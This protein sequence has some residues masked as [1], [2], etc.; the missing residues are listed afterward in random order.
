[1]LEEQLQ[2]HFKIP[3]QL[4]D[5]KKVTP[6]NLIEDLEFEKLHSDISNNT[7]YEFL[8]KPKTLFGRSGISQWIKNYTT[9]IQF[10]KDNQNLITQF[11]NCPNET[12]RISTTKA[13]LSFKNIKEDDNFIDKYQYIN[14]DKLEFLNKSSIF[15][16]I[17]SM[18]S[19][20][21]PALNII[22]PLLLLLI[23][24]ILLRFKKIPI[25]LSS[26]I[27]IL[28]V[29]LRNHSFGKLITQWGV[30]P[31]GQRIYMLLMVGMYIY[32]IYQN[33]ISCYQF[34]KNS[35]TINSDITNIRDHLKSMK[36]K[37]G[38][39]MSKIHKYKSFTPY[40]DYLQEKLEKIN[41]L[42]HNLDS[43]PLASFNPNKIPL[44]GYTMKQYYLLYKSEDIKDTLLFSFGFYGYLEKLESI[45]QLVKSK[46][47][48]KAQFYKSKK[49]RL[50]LSKAYY[51]TMIADKVIPNTIS[52]TR[53]KLI[54]GPNAS[55]KTT[56]LKTA[57]TNLLLSQQLGFG[58]YTKASITPFDYIHCYLN[59]PDTS[60]R[61]SLFQAEA[62][63]CLEILNTINN[64]KDKKHFCI[65]DELFSGTNPYEAISSAQSYLQHIS[66][67]SNV[68]FML[69]THFTKL[70]KNLN[71]NNSI[72][73]INMH[74][75][76]TDDIPSY[77]YT[78]CK[79]ISQI[80]GGIIVLKEL[81]YPDNI[82]ASTKEIINTF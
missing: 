15:L 19:I 55:G 9:D 16:S 69:T 5:N 36:N 43:V 42:H 50:R 1:M 49:P 38:N 39:F 23:P 73:N 48:N 61:D 47:L 52:M 74:T 4:I 18:Y 75:I 71:T 7:I 67:I 53:N 54:T 40:F 41:N 2:E 78:I 64:N 76:I 14:W 27:S 80:K 62:R 58:F 17:L 31:W 35:Y 11:S 8:L 37:L 22:A 60:S 24:F 66:G 6:P 12:D 82:V 3:I 33:A 68:R 26:Y 21:S 20:V 51:P 10:L 13:W 57:T 63:R 25:T 28:M 72:D 77:N 30:L 81:G 79:G 46:V 29:S 59:I 56:L 34:Y 44:L 70:C 32:N 45:S 65:F